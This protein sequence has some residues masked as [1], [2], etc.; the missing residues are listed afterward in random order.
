MKK[1]T[2]KTGADVRRFRESLG[3]TQTAFAEKV[4]Y[5]SYPMHISKIERGVVPVTQQLVMACQL[6]AMQQKSKH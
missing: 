5:T 1:L 4:G 2:I 3:M 6:L